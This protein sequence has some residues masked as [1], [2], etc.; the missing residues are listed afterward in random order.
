MNRSPSTTT[1]MKTPIEIQIDTFAD[2]SILKIFGCPAYRH[3]SDSKLRKKAQKCVF[4]DYQSGVKATD[5][6]VEPRS[7]KFI[8]SRDITFDEK[9]MLYLRKQLVIISKDHDID[10]QVESEIKPSVHPSQDDPSVQLVQDDKSKFFY[11]KNAH[12]SSST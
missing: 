9:A 2:Y 10:K 7:Q 1:K 11:E 3:I 12:R 8:V 4:L 5:Q 6:C